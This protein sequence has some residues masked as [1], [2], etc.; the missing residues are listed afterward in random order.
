LL[1]TDRVA[2]AGV[3]VAEVL[4]GFR[5]KDQAD[6]VASRLQMAH[7]EEIHWDDWRAAAE[8]ARDLAARG[9]RLPLTDLVLAAV[10][11]RC[12]APV[13]STDPHFDLITDLKCYWPDRP[14]D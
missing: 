4:M 6:C 5:R 7:Y 2:L 12:T 3:V 13:Y 9:N 11:K 14:G 8:F 1:D 10:A